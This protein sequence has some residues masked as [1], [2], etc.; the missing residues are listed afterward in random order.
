ME[1]CL[2]TVNKTIKVNGKGAVI[3]KP[4]TAS[5]YFIIETKDSTAESAQIKGARKMKNVIK[6]LKALDVKD[7]NIIT[8]HYFIDK[9]YNLKKR[10]WKQDGYI[11]RHHFIVKINDVNHVGKYIDKATKAGVTS[12]ES[13]SF[14]IS[15]PNEYY[16]Q[17]LRAAVKN[18]YSSAMT[19]S[20]TLKTTLG[21]CISIEE[22]NSYNSYEKE[23]AYTNSRNMIGEDMEEDTDL[24]YNEDIKY[25]DIKIIAG[26]VM[27]YIY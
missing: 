19:L 3:A 25:D 16:K 2:T 27:T 18:A 1:K 24:E 8:Q 5:I 21:E 14:S 10:I 4:D 6:T 11:A 22:I 9:N 15:N 7:V 20:E 13:V 23:I 26:V 17:A 12:V